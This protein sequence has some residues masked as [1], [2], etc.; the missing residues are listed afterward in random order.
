MI[1]LVGIMVKSEEAVERVNELLHDYREYVV[2]R[3]GLPVREQG[4]NVISI[5]LDAEAGQINGLTGK[6]GSIEGVRAKALYGVM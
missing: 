4:V 5:V 3:M 6:L 1:A 2:G